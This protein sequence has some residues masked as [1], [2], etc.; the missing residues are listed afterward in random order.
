MQ[1]HQRCS[2]GFSNSLSRNKKGEL[3]QKW[4]RKKSISISCARETSNLWNMNIVHANI[5]SN[6]LTFVTEQIIQHFKLSTPQL[7]ISSSRQLT[8]RAFSRNRQGSW[9]CAVSS[10]AMH[11]LGQSE[12]NTFAYFGHNL[13]WPWERSVLP[14]HHN[15]TS[16]LEKNT[17]SPGHGRR[18][19]CSHH[20][21]TI[22]VT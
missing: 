9:V 7:P 6:S 15:L 20:L 10:I 4:K 19:Y 21:L 16:Q 22:R 14:A 11:W 8:P 3:F 2:V 18:V 12:G 1:R 5:I 13:Q 17:I